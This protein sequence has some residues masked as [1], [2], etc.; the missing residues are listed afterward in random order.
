MLVFEGR[1]KPGEPREKPL[2]AE[3]RINN[4]LNPHMVSSLGINPEPHRWEEG[5]LTTAPSL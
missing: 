4:K 5:A 1:G 2:G 3:K